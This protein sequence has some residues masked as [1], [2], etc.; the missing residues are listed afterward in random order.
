MRDTCQRFCC[1]IFFQALIACVADFSKSL[2]FPETHT[3]RAIDALCEQCVLQK[4]SIPPLVSTNN[5]I[6]TAQGD[7]LLDSSTTKNDK[8]CCVWPVE[9]L[10][11]YRFEM[12]GL[13]IGLSYKPANI[14]PALDHKGSTCR[15]RTSAKRSYNLCYMC[16]WA[17]F[18]WT[19]SQRTDLSNVYSLALINL[20]YSYA[21][22][23]SIISTMSFMV[24]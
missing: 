11:R 5:N 3:M 2:F 20:R 19:S 14:K 23:I 15:A 7:L 24:A 17:T 8:S 10:K 4:L 22:Y 9:R 16:A 1:W 12:M 21:K 6:L 18:L 13:E